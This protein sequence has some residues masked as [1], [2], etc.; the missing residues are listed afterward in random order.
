VR[1]AIA[2]AADR[3]ITS[4]R[5]T[6]DE[7][8]TARQIATVVAHRMTPAM[9]K[10]FQQKLKTIEFYP[11]PREVADQ[12][13]KL[14]PRDSRSGRVGAFVRWPEFREHGEV[15]VPAYGRSDET[16]AH[17]FSHI[18]DGGRFS[19]I[20][21]TTAWR[22]AHATEIKAPGAPLSAYATT[23]ASEGFAEFGRLVMMQPEVARQQFPQCW[24]VWRDRKLVA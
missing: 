1:A 4:G 5:L 20:S 17:E 2:D 24:S 18:I 23:S 21:S 13:A 19:D 8:R 14:Y 6:P 12:H 3:A 10:R 7:G 22:A 9:A 16:Y 11:S 15:H